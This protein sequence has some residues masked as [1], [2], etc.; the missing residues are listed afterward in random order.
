VRER[1]L[2]LGRAGGD[3]ADDLAFLQQIDRPAQQ[4]VRVLFLVAFR[5]EQARLRR[6]A[7]ARFARQ[8]DQVLGP[9]P[10][11]RREPAKQRK[12]LRASGELHGA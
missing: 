2:R 5:E 10:V 8:G 4:V 7:S 3:R 11:E 12:I 1:I 9:H 6:L